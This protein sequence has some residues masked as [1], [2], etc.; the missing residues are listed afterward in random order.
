ML[1]YSLKSS[2]NYTWIFLK[3]LQ[4]PCLDI[5]TNPP[6]TIFGYPLKSSKNHGWISLKIFQKPYLDIPENPPKTML[7]CS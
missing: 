4:K 3:T 5:P 2:K 1:G 6:K 7:G